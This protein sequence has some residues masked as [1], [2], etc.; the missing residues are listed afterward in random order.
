MSFVHVQRLTQVRDELHAAR[1]A[2]A[3]VEREWDTIGADS[4]LRGIHLYQIQQALDKVGDT[5]LT[6]LFSDFERILRDH[7]ALRRP[8]LNPRTAES[9]VNRVALVERI[10]DPVRDTVHAVRA[11]RNAN[12]HQ[13][14]LIVPAV[15]FERALSALNIYLSRLP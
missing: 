13:G 8:G 10:P 5:Y 6:R 12:V 2:I 15:T 7:L 1:A 4:V 9:L 11:Y 3:Y 14:V